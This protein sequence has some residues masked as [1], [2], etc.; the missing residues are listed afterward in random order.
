PL[1][2][3]TAAGGTSAFKELRG[4]CRLDS[5]TLLLC[6]D[7]SV[8]KLSLADGKTTPVV[9]GLKAP[10]AVTTDATGNLYVSDLGDSQQIRKYS[11]EGK[12]LAVWGRAGGKAI[13]QVP[14]DPLAFSN[15]AHLAVG[16][17]GNLWLAEN[18]GP[19]RRFVKMTTEGKWLEDFCGPIAYN[20]FGPD[21]DDSS[22]VYYTSDPNGLFVETKLNYDRYIADP[23]KPGDGWHI[24]AIHDMTRGADGVTVNPL[25]AE[26]ARNGYGH[27]FVFKGPNDKKYFVRPSKGNRAAQPPGM[28][29]WV[30]E[31]EHWVPAVY[32]AVGDK[33]SSWTDRNGDGLVQED[34]TWTGT[35][36]NSV[37]WIGRDL[38]LEGFEGT[39]AP[40]SVDAR[41]VPQYQGGGFASYLKKGEP[42]YQDG[43]T[44]VSA[45]VDGAVYYV[46]NPGPE[47]HLSFWDRA[48]EN[49]VIK[50]KD[51]RVQWVIGDHSEHPD[52]T[53]LSTASGIAGVVDDVVMVHNVE[54]ANYVAYTTDGFTLGNAMVDA[55]GKRPS[56]GPAVINIESFTGMFIK[57]ATTGKRM[58]FTVSSGD[59]RILE[60]TGPGEL[61][62]LEG[63]VALPSVLPLQPMSEGAGMGTGP[64]TGEGVAL[65]FEV[66]YENWRGAN[67][68]TRAMDGI[69]AEWPAVKRGLPLIDL[70]SVKSAKTAK[71]G[72]NDK[73]NVI[74]DVRLRRDGGKLAVFANV[75]AGT[76]LAEGDGIEITLADAKGGQTRRFLITPGGVDKKGVAKSQVLL[77]G[78]A[79]PASGGAARIVPR[80]HSLGTR[81]E[82][83]ISLEV[84]PFAVKRPQ[85]VR[86]AAKDPVT[87]KMSNIDKKIEDVP[88]L[89][90]AFQISVAFVRKAADATARPKRIAAWPLEGMGAASAP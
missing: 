35:P 39:L 57:D 77:D 67:N 76:D 53:Q 40:A 8:V 26:V 34:E 82:A 20:T 18:A 65:A 14:Y 41:G 89:E 71:D 23:M 31:K 74:G 33:A 64:G 22:I 46:A 42:D 3:A 52:N 81:L 83:E 59:D 69:D 90:G 43:W 24:T 15:I 5:A 2:A 11:P 73:G 12:E 25:M 50:V 54:P 87:G 51:G 62:R 6:A 17:D 9:Q 61:T 47:R 72:G 48:D 88:D 19:P 44:F 70:E 13:N 85:T 28:G 29:L 75:L 27:V 49:R 86:V 55:D 1:G 66:A 10:Q 4:L 21:L 79:L 7:T 38:K 60:V 78:K 36:V 58:L 45:S 56:V 37:A 63:S 84:L 32:L 80:W 30:W 16:S 68:R